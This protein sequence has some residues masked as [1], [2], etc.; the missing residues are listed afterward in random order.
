MYLNFK[1]FSQEKIRIIEN[2]KPFIKNL[3]NN[4]FYYKSNS[5]ILKNLLKKHSSWN[6]SSFDGDI[7]LNY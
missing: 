5:I 4:N 3:P 6:P 7:L 1:N 2:F